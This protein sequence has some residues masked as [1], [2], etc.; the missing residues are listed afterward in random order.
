MFFDD[1]AVQFVVSDFTAS[2]P[3]AMSPL[4]MTELGLKPTV[5]R[6]SNSVDLWAQF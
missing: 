3:K 5:D 4:S 2:D 6:M 1:E